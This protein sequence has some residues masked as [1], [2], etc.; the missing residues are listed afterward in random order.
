MSSLVKTS[1]FFL[2]FTKIPWVFP[3]Q[4][5]LRASLQTYSCRSIVFSKN[6]LKYSCNSYFPIHTVRYLCNVA[7]AA[8]SSVHASS[9]PSSNKGSYKLRKKLM[10]KDSRDA[11]ENVLRYK[12]D[13]C[14]K[15]GQVVKALELYDEARSDG[16]QLILHHYNVLLYLCSSPSL[17]ETSG[18]NNLLS[19]VL[20][21]GLEIYQQMI[22][23]KVSPNEATFTSLARI[24]GAMDDPEMA[25]SLV[26][27]MEDY[28]IAPRLRS[29]GPALFGFCRKLMPEGAYEVDSHMLASA[30]EPEEPELSAL[31]KLSSDVKR[32]DKVYELLHRL[33][34][35]VRQV[36]EPTAKV[37][38]DWFNSESASEVGKKHWDV[39]K[40]REGIVRRGGGWHG[41]GW[42]GSGKWRLVR[43][44][45]D[46]NGVCHS[47]AQ[48]L[49]CIDIDPKETE[50]FASSLTK[51]ANQR[52]KDNF[53][54]F[55]VWL[56]KHGPF[57]AV[58]D[59]ANV[60]I[61]NDHFSFIQLKRAVYRM[62]ELS[63]SKKMPLI[64]LHT[65]RVTEGPARYPNNMKLIEIWKNCG[66]LYA[67]PYTSNDDWY[68]LYA[69]VRFKCLLLT[70]DEMR[71]HLF[72]LLGNTFFPQWKEKHQVRWSISRNG[73]KLHM[74]PPYSI[75]IQESENGSLHIPTTT[76]DD[77]ETPKQ[78]LCVT[79]PTNTSKSG[80]E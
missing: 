28:H 63:P 11:P 32:A 43:T 51:L 60:G 48:K 47:C 41:E 72:Q 79:R 59:G 19:V 36:S 21:R 10:K 68:W 40:V 25:F 18:A 23:D 53:G 4:N 8:T 5:T 62:R 49:V 7:S 75:V 73:L 50:D 24:A 66:A 44:G 37:I 27:Q 22:T 6:I 42:L 2:Y 29:Y 1:P 3:C 46:D 65:R 57:D 12:L 67:T 74:P 35:T 64:I 16:V 30:V 13:M 39:D 69:A 45:I 14:S 55:R 34:R 70:N 15:Y 17:L 26:K 76:G 61:E 52:V 71:D 33:R 80:F 38:E 78:W 9:T 31:L 58:I 54:K 56:E 20:S 77:I